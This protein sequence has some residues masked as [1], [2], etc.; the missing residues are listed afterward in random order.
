MLV[1]LN[2]GLSECRGLSWAESRHVSLGVDHEI[3]FLSL[4]TSVFVRVVSFL[5]LIL[6][7]LSRFLCLFDKSLE[8]VN[9]G[10]ARVIQ[11][12]TRSQDL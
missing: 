9:E 7:L 4:V 10:R 3:L 5:W 2:A 8:L 1:G 6:V 12:G 11:V